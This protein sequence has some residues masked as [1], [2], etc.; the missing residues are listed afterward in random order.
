[1]V[2]PGQGDTDVDGL[3]DACDSEVDTPVADQAGDLVPNTTDN[4]RQV[5]NHRQSDDDG[6]GIGD[7][8]DTKECGVWT[9]VLTRAR[10]SRAT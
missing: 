10:W 5:W 7:A 2:G 8:C 9:Q 3:G 1:M 4:C 6:D